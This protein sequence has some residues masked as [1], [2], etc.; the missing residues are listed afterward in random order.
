[1]LC[2]LQPMRV[3]YTQPCLW[4]SHIHI[5]L[6]TTPLPRDLSHGVCHA[7]M[8]SYVITHTSTCLHT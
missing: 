7:S 1:M 2:D 4:L 6:H 8:F 3:M 5:V